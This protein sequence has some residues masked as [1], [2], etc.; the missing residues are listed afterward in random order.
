M[1]RSLFVVRQIET[2]R[3]GAFDD[4]FDHGVSPGLMAGLVWGPHLTAR[5]LPDAGNIRD[6]G[7]LFGHRCRA[8]PLFGEADASTSPTALIWST[9]QAVHVE[10]SMISKRPLA[11]T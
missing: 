4:E 3:A 9:V 5:I 7:F 2:G 11:A 6:L 1:A 8:T 10:A